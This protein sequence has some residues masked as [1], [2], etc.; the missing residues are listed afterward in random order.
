MANHLVETSAYGPALLPVFWYSKCRS[1]VYDAAGVSSL[2]W[3]QLGF[4]S[5]D[6]QRSAS[7]PWRGDVRRP[8]F[9]VRCMSF[10]CGCSVGIKS[11]CCQ[12]VDVLAVVLAVRPPTWTIAEAIT[13]GPGVARLKL[14]LKR[15]YFK[16]QRNAK[17][18]S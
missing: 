6:L 8:R 12:D 3:Q 2:A 17:G 14:L 10:M 13:L 5:I 1:Q 7:T 15:N 16:S 4:C 9:H 11:S 18:S